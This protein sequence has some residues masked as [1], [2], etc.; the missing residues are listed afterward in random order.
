MRWKGALVQLPE[1]DD[2]SFVWALPKHQRAGQKGPDRRFN[3][4]A[5]AKE[6]NATA[7]ISSN[8]TILVDG[9]PLCKLPRSH[10]PSQ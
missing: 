7:E 5:M 10:A 4:T 8:H 1:A 2:N 3:N 6:R 9:A